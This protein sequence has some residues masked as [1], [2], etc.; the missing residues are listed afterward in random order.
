MRLVDDDFYGAVGDWLGVINPPDKPEKA[1]Q[2]TIF[3]G[4]WF[5]RFFN[6]NL[7]QSHPQTVANISL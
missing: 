4:V 3:S 2:P 7:V 5:L 1:C 6:P